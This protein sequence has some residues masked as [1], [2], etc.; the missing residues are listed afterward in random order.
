MLDLWLLTFLYVLFSGT[1]EIPCQYSLTESVNVTIARVVHISGFEN[2]TYT[3]RIKEKHNEIR[4]QEI[5][6]QT[7]FEILFEWLK[8]CTVYNISVDGCKPNGSETFISSEK[9]DT[10][11]KTV[12]TNVTEKKV[13]L[14]GEFTGIK[15]N[16]TECVEITE[17]NSC[18]STHTI[19][20]DKCNYTMNV[21][22]PTVKPNITFK[23]T[24]PSKFEWTNKPTQCNAMLNINC[25]NDENKNGT[26]YG[27]NASVSLLPDTLYSCIGVYPYENQ[28]I[29]S[30]ELSFE[31]NCGWQKNGRFKNTTK[32]SF[33]ISWNSL[34]GDECSGI[35]WDSYSASCKFHDSHREHCTKHKN[36]I[37][38]D[39]SITNLLP[40]KNY[41]CSIYA[42]FKSKKYL[43]FSGTNATLS[44]KPD[45]KSDIEVTHPFHNSLDIICENKGTKIVWNGEKGTFM[46]EITYNGET[47][48]K[49]RTKCSFTFPDLYYLTTYDVKITAENKEGH[50]AVLKH[51]ATTKYNDKAVIG[52]LAF[53]IIVTSVALLFVL[54]KIY[55]L[56]RKRTA[57]DEEILL[58]PEPLRRVEPI[59]ADGLVEAYKSKIADEARLFMDEFQS[60]PRIF[61][62]YTIKEAKKP[63]NQFKN[64]YVDILPYDYNRVTL[65]TGG[66]ESYINASFIEGYQEP[67]KYIAAQGPKDETIG[68]FWRMVWEQKSSIIVMVTRCEEGNKIKCAQYWPSLDRETEIFEDFVVKIRSEEHCPDYIIRHL[69]LTN[70]RE[71]A[72]E[73]EVTHIQFISWPD[74]GVPGDPCL[75]LKLR[76]RVNSFKNFFSGPVVV[77]CSAG[78]G[79][80][81]TYIGIDA[82][83]ES[84]E[85]EGRVDIYGFVAK[86]R[87]QRCLMVQVEAQYILIHTALIEHN[88][89]GETEVSLSEFHSVLNTLRQ[90][91]G[92]DP[93]LL[94]MEFLKLPKFKK[95]RT[96]NTGSIEDNKKKNRDSAV[97]PYDFNR[98]LFRLDIEGNQT[99]DPEDEDEYSSDEEEESNEYINASFI[100]GYWCSKSLIAAQGPL[101]NT[102]EEFLLMLDQQQTKTLVMLTD[103]QEDGKDY[104]CQYW[105]DEKKTFGDMEIEVKKT[106]TF[107]TYVRRRLEIQSSK[108]KEILE[109]DQYQFLKWKGRELPE[110]AQE[111]IEMTR[112]IRENGNYDNSKMNRNVPIVVHCNNGSSRTGIFCALWNLLDSAYTEKLVDV[113]QEVKNLRKER[114]GMV[115]TI[116][117]YQFLYSALEAA[118]PVQNGAVKTTPAKDSA[119]V[120]SETTALLTEPNSTSGADQ[121]EAEE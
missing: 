30:N 93:S 48:S 72:S 80:T 83:I 90:K 81:G 16:L 62:N 108:K 98:V 75:L 63:E 84:V 31:I 1:T 105:G 14:K 61:S 109:V 56:K 33:E 70:K 65:S 87:R 101:P 3:I 24:I 9:I 13:C 115:E 37:G 82:M 117:Q 42:E 79:R 71:K 32:D 59:Y 106:E 27:L 17:Q 74:H 28:S 2:Q 76:R 34:D 97:I 47:I 118:F 50:S 44:T 102:T 69:I 25:T 41:E 4:V 38:T 29:K 18:T 39:C 8:P 7:A 5:S 73:R 12:V 89:F 35:T 107:P 119:Q 49:N 103:C 77:H 15:W 86:Q 92:S 66:E 99:S 67:K 36:G 11:L 116:E 52:F 88:Q 10:V 95:W 78:V 58:T 113:F 53:L 110:N 120:I 94:E 26:I 45:F 64:R 19:K 68:D 43:L 91:D 55:L 112:I 20:L 104:C 100:N 21:L 46:A 51:E 40:Y 22:M 23:K 60:I 85:A 54:F 6:N 114:Q 121:K 111:L 57:E 96:F